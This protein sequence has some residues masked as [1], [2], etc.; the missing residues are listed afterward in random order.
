[1]PRTATITAPTN[2]MKMV[3]SRQ[4]HAFD[5]GINQVVQLWS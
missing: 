1:M 5:S 4:P 3:V 2:V